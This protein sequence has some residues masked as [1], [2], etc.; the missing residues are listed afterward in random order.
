[1]G[2]C[3]GDV[4]ISVF[5]RGF[6]EWVEEESGAFVFS[7]VVV[8][9]DRER[10]GERALGVSEVRGQKSEVRGRRLEVRGQRSE[11]GISEARG[12]KT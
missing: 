3:A 8:V 9:Q 10:E 1:M 6:R 2:Q 7:G 11:V 12:Q 5:R 4:E